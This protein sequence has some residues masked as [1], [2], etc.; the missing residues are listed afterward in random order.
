MFVSQQCTHHFTSLPFV[1]KVISCATT[2]LHPLIRTQKQ[3]IKRRRSTKLSRIK[4][5]KEYHIDHALIKAEHGNHVASSHGSV[6]ITGGFSGSRH[7]VHR[8]NL[9]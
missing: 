3:T 2:V 7:Q 4:R 6:A 5:H 9:F 1:Q 8:I